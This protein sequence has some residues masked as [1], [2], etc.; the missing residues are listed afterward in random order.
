MLDERR[1]GESAGGVIPR[2]NVT[3]PTHRPIIK[4][5]NWKIKKDEMTIGECETL[6]KTR[7][8]LFIP[9]HVAFV[10]SREE[11]RR[12]VLTHSESLMAY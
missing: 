2:F 1:G 10:Y 6:Q 11:V 4:G 7:I 8:S 3:L 9:S 12:V 5:G